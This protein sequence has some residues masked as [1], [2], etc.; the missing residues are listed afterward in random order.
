M[1][2]RLVIALRELAAA[3]R[4][5]SRDEALASDFDDAYFLF[6]QC[7]QLEVTAGQRDAL[8]DVERHL[9]QARSQPG[10]RRSA[11]WAAV[12]AAAT[13]ALRELVD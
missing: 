3:E 10:A 9:L 5:E 8:A 13:A 4:E 1:I 7:Q 6:S 12:R 2:E 11:D